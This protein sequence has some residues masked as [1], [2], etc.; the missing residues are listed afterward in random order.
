M[1]S[2]KF[3]ISQV[4]LTPNYDD[5]AMAVAV[6]KKLG[7]K[8]DELLSW[9]IKKRSIDARRG[10]ACYSLTV[11]AELGERAGAKIEGR[12]NKLKDV[13]PASEVR[14]K[15]RVA[16]ADKTMI[17]GRPVV[18]GSGPAGLFAAYS[19]VLAGLAPIIVE[20]G[21]PVEQRTEA[22]EKLWETGDLNSNANVQFGE[23]GAGTFSDGKLFTGGKDRDGKFAFVL[24]TFAK[25]GADPSI[26]YDAKPH[27]GTDV[28]VTVLKNLREEI[29]RLGGEYRFLTRFKRFDARD[30]K[31][32]GLELETMRGKS[33]SY[34]LPCETAVLAIGHSARDTMR[35]L[36][37]AGFALEPKAFA[38]GFR[39]EHN[40]DFIS[41]TQYGEN[42]RDFPPADYK[43]TANIGGRGVYSFCMCPGGY[44][45]NASSEPGMM[46]VNGMSYK[47]R[48][49]GNANSA[50]VVAVEPPDFAEF[51]PYCG[52]P[53]LAGLIFQEELEKKA[54]LLGNGNVPVQLFG[55]FARS[56]ESRGFGSISPKVKGKYSFA[57]M[58]GLLPERLRSAFIG[59]MRD[60]GRKIKGF[61]ADDVPIYG[62]EGRTSSAVR[63]VRDAETLQSMSVK[64]VYPCGEGAGYAGGITSS[65]ADGLRVA[66]KILEGAK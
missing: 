45:V 37:A 58:S 15:P 19:L 4:K 38:V 60:F 46:V 47:A 6:C 33:E 53:S 40:Q 5:E 20:R 48:A 56:R 32:A 7:I 41:K 49:S 28:L 52:E 3:R 21:L 17:G 22:V 54:F 63:M 59:G 9:E 50:I 30:G 24:E 65:A 44:V 11:D 27:V 18:I 39:V 29:E 2:T 62:I 26:V 61:D 64:G 51:C 31:L 36:S 34:Y 23:G 16:V 8:R 43:L 13:A 1:M 10:A 55:D 12:V 25:F 57:D 35:G 14:Y 42:F 66:E